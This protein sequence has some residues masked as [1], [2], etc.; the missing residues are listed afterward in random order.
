MWK[1]LYDWFKW[2]LSLAFEERKNSVA[3]TEL[4]RKIQTLA[5]AMQRMAYEIQRNKENEAHEREKL[6]LTI[7]N[8]VLRSLLANKQLEETKERE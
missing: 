6:R 8:E 4:D 3:I 7:E 1:Q 2:L 5:E